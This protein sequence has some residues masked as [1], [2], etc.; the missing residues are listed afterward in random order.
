MNQEMHDFSINNI[1][2]NLGE[3]STA[4]EIVARL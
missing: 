4:D 2:S 1:L 3:I